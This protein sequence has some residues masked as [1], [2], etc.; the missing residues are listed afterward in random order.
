MGR[1][2]HGTA[3]R[4]KGKRKGRNRNEEEADETE[5]TVEEVEREIRK[6]KKE[7]APERN[8]VQNEAWMYRTEG[9]V[10]RQAEVM[11]GVWRGKAFPAD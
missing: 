3:G 10:E 6:L 2:L 7:K 4:E 11:N 1:V 8:V 9:I 5:I